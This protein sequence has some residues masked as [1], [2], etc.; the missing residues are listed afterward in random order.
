MG[1]ELKFIIMG[2]KAK[3]TKH[4]A[5]E[6]NAKAAQALTDRGG[7]KSGIANRTSGHSKAK[8]Y[9]CLADMPSVASLKIHFDS[10][11]PKETFDEGKV[12]AIEQNLKSAGAVPTYVKGKLTTL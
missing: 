10:K 8:C 11:H 1:T 4:T 12:I 5:K 3:M 2:G 9:V 7:G 6:L